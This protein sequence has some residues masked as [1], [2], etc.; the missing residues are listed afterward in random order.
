MEEYERTR[1]HDVL[2]EL[3]RHALEQLSGNAGDLVLVR[4]SLK[5]GE[6]RVVDLRGEVTLVLCTVKL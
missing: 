3:G 6:H 5:R 1:L 2:L 4:A